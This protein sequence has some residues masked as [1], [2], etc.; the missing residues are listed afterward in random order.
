[1]PDTWI[2][3]AVTEALGVFA[4]CFIGI[5]AINSA[6]DLTGIALA[7]GLAIAVMVAALGHVSGGHFNPAITLGLFLGRKIDLPMAGVYW[8]A[9]L[10]GGVIAAVVV[11]LTAPGGREAVAIGT[12]T[13]AP[14][15]NVLVGI[16]LEMIATFFLVLV[17]YGTVVDRRAPAS[18][19]PF[20]IG[21]TITAGILAI[22]AFT[23]G[24]LNP[25]RGF[26]PALV[27]GVWGGTLAW[28]IG[29]LL[30]GVAAWALHT[31]VLTPRE[32]PE[33]IAE[34]GRR[35]DV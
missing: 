19:Y 14:D 9:Q 20:A 1:M 18:V 16:V 4:L 3:N 25:A 24:A 31:Y 12:P 34:S 22:G 23:G 21:L 30:G 15:I 27:G 10:L 7:H 29:P 6:A 28:L 32:E 2:R 26:G 17:V 11:A 35:K 33:S 13:L 5:M 8:V